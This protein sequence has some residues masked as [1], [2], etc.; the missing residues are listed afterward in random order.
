MT[1]STFAS[2]LVISQQSIGV[3]FEVSRT[4]KFSAK[5]VVMLGT[6]QS[7]GLSGVDSE[8]MDDSCSRLVHPPKHR[9]GLLDN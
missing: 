6:L 1:T 8:H 4:F 3:A 5:L 7:E 2:G 9:P